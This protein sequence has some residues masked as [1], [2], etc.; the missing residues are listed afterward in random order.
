M[1]ILFL[2][3]YQSCF[4]KIWTDAKWWCRD[5][6]DHWMNRELSQGLNQQCQ[7]FTLN[8]WWQ[9]AELHTFSSPLLVLKGSCSADT[10]DPKYNSS[11]YHLRCFRDRIEKPELKSHVSHW[12][13]QRPRPFQPVAITADCDVKSSGRLRVEGFSLCYKNKVIFTL[14]VSEVRW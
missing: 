13:P 7:M 10:V 9:R 2:V 12:R 6:A 1:P 3:L 14:P 8:S 4:Q 5:T 11:L